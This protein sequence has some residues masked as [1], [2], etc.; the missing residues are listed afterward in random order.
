MLDLHPEGVI[1]F[2][3]PRTFL[4]GKGYRDVRIALISRFSEIELVSLPDVVFRQS[5]S[6]QE[7]VLLI[8]WGP[9]VGGNSS[10][11]RHR[12]VSKAD[13]PAFSRLYQVTSEE[14]GNTTRDK[15]AESLALP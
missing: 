7:T 1:G 4:D 9:Q 6:E 5:G 2:V 10:T 11:V 12:R 3:L 13:W 15:A 8:A 14:A